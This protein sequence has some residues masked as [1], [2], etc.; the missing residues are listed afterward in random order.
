[1]FC[2]RLPT[3]RSPD[4]AIR[5]TQSPAC[6]RATSPQTESTH[7]ARQPVP[8][9][10]LHVSNHLRGRPSHA[11]S[12]RCHAAHLA[13][14]FA[15]PYTQSAAAQSAVHRPVKGRWSEGNREP[16]EVFAAFERIPAQSRG[17][18]N[19]PADVTTRH[20]K[21]VGTASD[22]PTLQIRICGNGLFSLWLQQLC[23]AF[24]FG[25]APVC[26]GFQ[27]WAER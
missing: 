8:L 19:A 15:T 24:D 18:Y 9:Q 2:V 11:S 23:R 20:P 13:D 3:S 16:A 6:H 5:A 14:W 17:N 22:S 4:L 7:L 27:D 25:N 21:R 10:F 12:A 26:N 1:M